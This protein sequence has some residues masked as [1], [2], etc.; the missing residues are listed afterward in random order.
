[1]TRLHLP[2]QFCWAFPY[3]FECRYPCPIGSKRSPYSVGVQLL[4]NGTRA[5]EASV[6]AYEAR[7]R[8]E[9]VPEPGRARAQFEPLYQALLPG[10]YARPAQVQMPVAGG[11][12]M[13]WCPFG[14][15]PRRLATAV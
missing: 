10:W 3:A 12:K 2:N 1:V 13:R 5:P 7:G 8:V 14:P 9:V 11:K 4:L 15:R 6:Q